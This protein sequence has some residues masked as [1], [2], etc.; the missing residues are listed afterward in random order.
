MQNIIIHLNTSKSI[1]FVQVSNIVYLEALENYTRVQLINNRTITCT[2]TFGKL[3]YQLGEMGF[4]KC[5][6][7]YAIN[8]FNIKRLHKCNCV[9]EMING[10]KLPLARRRKEDFMAR[11]TDRMMQLN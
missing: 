11:I 10:T 5:H 2:D 7:S 3:S 8:M 1:E 9:V 6:K 4:F